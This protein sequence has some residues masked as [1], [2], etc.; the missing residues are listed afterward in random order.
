MPTGWTEWISP[1][2]ADI[3]VAADAQQC[4]NARRH[5]FCRR[6]RD[7]VVSWQDIIIRPAVLMYMAVFALWI[8]AAAKLQRSRP[9][10]DTIRGLVLCCADTCRGMCRAPLESSRRGGQ[11][12]EY[13]ARLCAWRWTCRRRCRCGSSGLVV[14][15]HMGVFRAIIC[16]HGPSC[17]R[18]Q[19]E[20][21]TI[22]GLVQAICTDMRCGMCH[23]TFGKGIRCGWV[24]VL[25][26]D[27][28]I[29]LCAR[30]CRRRCRYRDESS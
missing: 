16:D 23:T 30:R 1:I 19:P 8:A 9:K 29:R 10:G 11:R 2:Y 14:L 3:L 17:S 22:R 4:G 7:S 13:L 20:G 5:F 28:S 21:D 6:R 12:T 26:P 24:I 27:M 18:S 25:Y 15:M